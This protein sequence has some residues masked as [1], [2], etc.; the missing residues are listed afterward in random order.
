MRLLTSSKRELYVDGVTLK[1][2]Q[3]PGRIATTKGHP[4]TEPHSIT[5]KPHISST[6]W[7]DQLNALQEVEFQPFRRQTAVAVVRVLPPLHVVPKVLPRVLKFHEYA[8]TFT[9]TA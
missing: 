8:V 3:A 7:G 5:H 9:V 1:G 4:S 6:W 2:G